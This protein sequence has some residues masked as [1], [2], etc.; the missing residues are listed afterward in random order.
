MSK[1][2]LKSWTNISHRRGCKPPVV[3]PDVLTSGPAPLSTVG[4][5]KVKF[6][7]D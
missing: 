2:T 7:A 1:Q 4:D 6:S 3:A 5:A